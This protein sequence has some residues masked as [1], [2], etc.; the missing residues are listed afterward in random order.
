MISFVETYCYI[1]CSDLLYVVT[2]TRL[3][4]EDK[5]APGLNTKDIPGEHESA[6][7]SVLQN[8]QWKVQ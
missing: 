7:I 3:R 2:T 8:Y 6:I 5:Y 4:T 1:Y